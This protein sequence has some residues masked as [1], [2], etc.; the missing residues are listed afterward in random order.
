MTSVA[1]DPPITE[2]LAGWREGD[3]AALHKLTPLVYRDLRRIAG[4]RLRRERAGN[5]LEPTA[6]VHEAYVQLSRA[7]GV[8][9]EDRSHFFEIASR[10]MQQILIQRARA[11]NAEKRGGG[12]R[13]DFEEALALTEKRA[14][15]AMQVGEAVDELAR[16]DSR[17]AAI[18]EMRYFSGMTTHEI[19]EHLGVSTSTVERQMRIALAWLHRY[20]KTEDDFTE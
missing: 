20:L 1:G 7:A 2:L 11:R 10:L 9:W 4:N 13:A 16:E 14:A 18:V 17:K 3:A 8:G 5:T 12:R 15:H 19:A 6:L